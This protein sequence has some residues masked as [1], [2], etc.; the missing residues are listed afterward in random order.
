M[1]ACVRF[2]GFCVGAV[3]LGRECELIVLRVCAKSWCEHY[4]R[5]GVVLM[6]LWK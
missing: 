4:C 1:D 3:V 5:S 2:E 6:S